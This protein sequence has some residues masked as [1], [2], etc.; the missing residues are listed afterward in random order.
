MNILPQQGNI[1]TLRTLRSLKERL[2]FTEEEIKEYKIESKATPDGNAYI[3]WGKEYDSVTTYID[4]GENS[5]GIIVQQL[6]QLNSKGLLREQAVS[7]WDKFVE[8]KEP[9]M[10]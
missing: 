3:V 4:I 8:N 6:M 7:L 5:S 10:S 9:S 1:L 2:V